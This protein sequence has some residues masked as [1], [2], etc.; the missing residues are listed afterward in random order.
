MFN[1]KRF[2]S[3]NQKYGHFSIEYSHAQLYVGAAK[4]AAEHIHGSRECDVSARSSLGWVASDLLFDLNIYSMRLLPI[5]DR[6]AAL[7]KRSG[8][9][10]DVK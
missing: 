9:T 10:V 3:S 5:D 6:Y 8:N 1:T 2:S 7:N 4:L